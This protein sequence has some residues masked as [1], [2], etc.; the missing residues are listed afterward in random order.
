MTTASSGHTVIA[1]DG[2]SGVGK[3][4]AAKRLAQLLGYCYVDSGALY[5]AVGLIVATAAVPF[6]APAAIVEKL[7]QA[8]MRVTF[9]AGQS[10]VWVQGQNVTSQL[11]GETVG[12]AAS[13]IAKQPAVRQA[14]T[15]QLRRLRGQTDVVMEGR[16]IGTIVF[17][18]APVKFFLD[19]SLEVR[20]Q[21]RYHEMQAAGQ[22]ATLEEVRHAVVARDRQDRTRAVA[23]LLPANDAHVVDTTD[24]SV[25]DVVQVMLSE[26]YPQRV[27]GNE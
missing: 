5:R 12:A 14:I 26:I 21:R 8:A 13:A 24:L 15:A 2:P 10:A 3:S 25:D 16:D 22:T 9:E 7:Q 23:P 18:D 19:A 11:R 27:Q 17:P 6:D 4:T 20:I 1:I